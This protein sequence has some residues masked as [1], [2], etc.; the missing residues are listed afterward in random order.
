MIILVNCILLIIALTESAVLI[1][2]LYIVRND[3]DKPKKVFEN[4]PIKELLFKDKHRGN[5]VIRTEKD[6]CIADLVSN[7][8]R[9][10]VRIG[11]GRYFYDEEYEKMR[12][13]VLKKRLP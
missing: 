12:Q 7:P 4:L 11:T 8:N 6:K 1:F 9:G 2:F 10:S 13:S 3:E 5:A